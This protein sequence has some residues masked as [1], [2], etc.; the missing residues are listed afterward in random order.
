M[1][2]GHRTFSQVLVGL[3]PV[4]VQRSSNLSVCFQWVSSV[5]KPVRVPSAN[6][7]IPEHACELI[8]VLY[9]L[10]P[11]FVTAEHFSTI[12]LGLVVSSVFFANFMYI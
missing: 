5:L 9:S 12:K 2:V 7:S 8:P 1:E 10:S 11:T 4:F 3:S 6:H